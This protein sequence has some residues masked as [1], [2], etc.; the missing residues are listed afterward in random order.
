MR[1]NIYNE[2]NVRRVKFIHSKWIGYFPLSFDCN[3]FAA[4]EILYTVFKNDRE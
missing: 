3:T 1:Y 2:I 4:L